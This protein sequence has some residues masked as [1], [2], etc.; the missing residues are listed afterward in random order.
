MAED[1]HRIDAL[2]EIGGREPL[3]IG[4]KELAARGVDCCMWA[5]TSGSFVFG[6]EGAQGQVRDIA[7]LLGVPASS[8]S[9]SFV[10]ALER[11]GAGRVAI[12]ATYPDDV[13]GAADRLPEEPVTIRSLADDLNCG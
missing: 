9:F 10:R 4:A 7:E 11:L 5:C 13:A 2:L 8:T 3:L 12:A 1:A 6:W